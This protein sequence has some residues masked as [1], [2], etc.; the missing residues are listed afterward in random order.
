LVK[1]IVIFLLLLITFSPSSWLIAQK[2][3]NALILYSITEQNG[4]SDNGVTCL[5]Q[6][7]RGFMWIGTMDGFNRYDGSAVRIFKTTTHDISQQGNNSINSIT[8]DAR[9]Q[10]WV[11]T[12]RGLNMYD[13]RTDSV[14]TWMNTEDQKGEANQ[15]K[16]LVIDSSGQIWLGTANGLF[17]FDPVKK[18]FKS[19]TVSD[20]KK[21]NY[22]LSQD[23]IVSLLID[24]KQRFWLATYSGLWRFFREDGHF[25]Q[26]LS[27]KEF[28]SADE[29]VTNL[30]EDHLGQ[31]WLTVWDNGVNVFDPVQRKIVRRYYNPIGNSVTVAEI[32]DSKGELKTYLSPPLFELDLK[33]GMITDRLTPS[34][35]NQKS[36]NVIQLY[37]S[38]DNLLW[39]ATDDGVRIL[40]P[41][42]QVFDHHYI[43]D[44]RISTQGITLLERHN[45]IYV[46][47]SGNNFLQIY[48]SNFRIEKTLLS[49]LTLRESG[50]LHHPA[51]LN[52]VSEDSVR[53]WLC[54]EKGLVL[55]NERT[56]QKKIY[57]V[58]PAENPSPT[59]NFINNLFIDS[60]GN[61]W[62]FP[63][64]SGIWQLDIKTGAF[65]KIISGFL[66]NQN[67][68]K[69]LLVT[70]AVE[71]HL[72]NIWFS[73]LDEGLIQYDYRS[74]SFSK[75]AQPWLGEKFWMAGII[76][77]KPWI[78]FI[79]VASVCRMNVETK[80]LE[81]F[82]F[83]EAF[84]KIA[85][86]FC[87]DKDNHI[88]I[89][90][91]NG[92]LSFDKN[93]HAFKR[94]TNNDGLLT[95]SLRGTLY[96][97]SNGK[98]LYASENYITSFDPKNLL[99]S[100]TSA[101][102][103]ITGVSSQNKVVP[104]SEDGN[105]RKIIRLNY[106]Y[107][108]FT[109]YWALPNYSNPLQNQYYC[110]LEEVEKDWRYVGTRGEAHYAS[111]E[112]GSYLFHARATAGNGS[113]SKS[114]D[115]IIIIIDPPFWKS[116]WF[117]ALAVAAVGSLTYII[118]R[119][120]IR[121][122]LR[123]ER[124]RTKISSDLH[125]D[126]G[127]TLSSI[128]ILSEIVLKGPLSNQTGQMV[129]EIK[130]NS[131][132]LMEKMDDIVWS[133]NPRNDSLEN[134]LLRIK[135]FAAA[136]FE[137][138]NIE[139]N[140]EIQE[141]VKKIH[142]AMDYR[143]HIYL[144]MKEAINNVVKHADA[145]LAS[146]TVSYQDDQLK[147]EIKDNGKG[148]EKSKDYSGNGIFSMKKRAGLMKAQLQIDSQ[149]GQGTRILLQTRVRNNK[150]V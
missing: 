106:S 2:K 112:P 122:V 86:G 145:S 31:I 88:W 95:N 81:R 97:L 124:L 71:D 132:S 73:D 98:I 4:L 3:D 89:T 82:P 19:Y 45:K 15:I 60:R 42:K 74:N 7:S 126:I 149:P 70:D 113:F 133:I 105:G 55:Y 147:L 49:D 11:G 63:W 108:N 68:V 129:A 102:V 65:K 27:G 96:T 135:R 52:M 128:S 146:I 33:T 142:L 75:P 26:Y 111:L 85:D 21:D 93:T 53:L 136:L 127:S 114:D 123:M 99:Q 79:T 56:G 66:K 62:V 138:K 87:V 50:K 59:A 69:Q 119:Y 9:H 118:I 90:T 14:Y 92:L 141:N 103:L 8:E 76:S 120:R 117:I 78:W 91:L 22:R 77:E 23:F 58:S 13:P 12:N 18:K 37:K 34:A 125:D 67:A 150:P 38:R 83:P 48:D 24:S 110:K 130:E 30:F 54:T 40:D 94:F 51:L 20:P 41:A 47:G 144:F 140:I 101:K 134:L 44:Q 143:Q 35:P 148:L 36:L 39:L 121:Q 137:A 139:Y 17:S 57:Q 109:F 28:G 100:T 43:S 32:N 115:E 6:D 61:H 16:S 72:G 10:I 25:E 80:K 131:L 29:L 116:W 5:F 107:N 46:G 104:I 84:N 64:R 1:R